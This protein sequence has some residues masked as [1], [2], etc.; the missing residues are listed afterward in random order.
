MAKLMLEADFSIGAGGAASWERCS[1][2]L[3]SLIFSLADNQ[4]A[5]AKELSSINAC[6]Y[7]GNSDSIDSNDLKTYLLRLFED[8]EQI[9]QQSKNSFSTLDALGVFRV[10]DEI[11]GLG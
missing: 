8:K 11:R 9:Q 3:P 1:L 10:T 5:I 6:T 4:V 2:G 7:A